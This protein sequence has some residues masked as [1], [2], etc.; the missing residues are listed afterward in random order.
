MAIIYRQNSEAH[1][2]QFYPWTAEG[3]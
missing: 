2:V 3:N 1:G